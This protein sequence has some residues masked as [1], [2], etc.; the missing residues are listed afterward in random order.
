[1]IAFLLALS[2]PLFIKDPYYLHTAIM[3]LLNCL[4]AVSLF[5]LLRSGLFSVAHAAFMAVG[6]YCSA[7][8]VMKAGVN[9]WIAMPLSGICASLVAVVVG[10]P[11]LRTKGMAF[12]LITFSLNEVMRLVINSWKT[13]TGGPV[14]ISEIP[15][16]NPFQIGSF[17]TLKFISRTANY[18]LVLALLII[19]IL[20]IY[21]LWNSRLGRN[22]DL[23]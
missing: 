19:T 18:Y 17:F 22:L 23:R 16:P 10:T 9:F 14:G 3:I 11:V 13:V 6:A 20:V 7:L 4:L 2:I 15:R 5:P 1:M 12:M 8:L 21:S